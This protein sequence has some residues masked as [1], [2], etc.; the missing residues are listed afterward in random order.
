MKSSDF[1]SYHRYKTCIA[2]TRQRYWSRDKVTFP[3]ISSTLQ[4][5]CGCT[6][7]GNMVEQTRFTRQIFPLCGRS[8][9]SAWLHFQHI[10]SRS[11]NRHSR[12]LFKKYLMLIESDSNAFHFLRNSN[13]VI[14]VSKVVVDA[15]RRCAV[16]HA[17]AQT[18]CTLFAP[19]GEAVQR[20]K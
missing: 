18:I 15:D 10:G 11:P 16:S 2:P 19:V 1:L 14:N 17:Q 5:M 4:R 8:L 6:V 13:G 9:L 7:H 3:V 20:R 12:S